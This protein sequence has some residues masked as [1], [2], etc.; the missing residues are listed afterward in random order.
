ML[1]DS[2]MAQSHW[3]EAANTKVYLK[4]RSPSKILGGKTPYEA[5]YGTRPNL[6]HLK[7]FGCLAIAYNHDPKRRKLDDKGIKCKFL[8]YKG[9]NQYRL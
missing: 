6:S 3:G 7:P 1:H 8:G 4:N 9:S 5:W 2:G